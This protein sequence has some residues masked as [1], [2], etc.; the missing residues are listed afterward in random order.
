MSSDPTNSFIQTWLVCVGL[1]ATFSLL[2]T[3]AGAF[4]ERALGGS[5]KIWN[6]DAIGFLVGKGLLNG[7]G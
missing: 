5:R 1:V 6:L 4:F 3:A 7:G 2:S